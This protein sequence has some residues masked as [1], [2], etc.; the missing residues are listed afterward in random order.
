M[1]KHEPKC[2]LSAAAEEEQKVSL[3][4]DGGGHGIPIWQAS[5]GGCCPQSTL[6]NRQMYV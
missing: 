6:V 1:E 2:G 3:S 4:S 5:V